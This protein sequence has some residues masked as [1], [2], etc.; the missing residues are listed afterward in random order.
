MKSPQAMLQFLRKR[1]LDAT[2]KLAGN[3]DFGVAVCEVLD[4]LIRRT[5][6]IA[7]EYPASSKMSLRDILEMPAVVG[8][9]QAIL[10]TVAALS[11]VASECADATAAR[12]DPVLKFVARVK[13]EGF[14]V[15]ND[16]TLTDTRVQ[17][18]AHTD[19]PALLVQREAEKIARAEQAAAYH[20]RLLRMAAAF[21]DTTIEYTQRVRGLIGT[22]LDG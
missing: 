19:D 12:R 16:W 17:P 14:E 4:E 15:A 13:A 11:D 1:R 9:M 8:A 20:E 18:H 5:Q 6:V 2:E 10:E 7:N 22:A 21:E 3:G